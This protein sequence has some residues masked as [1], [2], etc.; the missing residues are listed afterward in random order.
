M[1]DA[2]VGRTGEII[3]VAVFPSRVQIARDNIDEI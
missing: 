1:R 2:I 3:S